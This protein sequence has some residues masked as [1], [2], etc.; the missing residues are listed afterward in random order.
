MLEAR[1]YGNISLKI[2]V[3]SLLWQ[4]IILHFYPYLK[5][6]KN[7]L[8]WPTITIRLLM[9]RK[10]HKQHQPVPK[11]I[12]QSNLSLQSCNQKQS[13]IMNNNLLFKP[14]LPMPLLNRNKNHNKLKNNKNYPLR[15][16]NLRK[17]KKFIFKVT[18]LL[19]SGNIKLNSGIHYWEVKIDKL[20][21]NK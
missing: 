18:F 21:T 5:E 14:K 10:S 12:P 11:R 9:H 7:F 17:I 3:E 4:N 16:Q 8:P 1:L 19:Y 6:K 13:K 15:P 20:N 2:N